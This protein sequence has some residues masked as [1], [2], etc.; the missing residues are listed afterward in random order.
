MNGF[1]SKGLVTGADYDR[2]TGTLV[3]VGYVKSIW[4]PFVYLIYN[5]DDAGVN[6]SNHR[7]EMPNHLSIQTEGVCFYASGKCYISSEK[8]KTFTPRVFKV[9]FTKWISKDRKRK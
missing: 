7:F 3:I 1:D 4:Q 9:D 5:F 2:E 6:L 8:S